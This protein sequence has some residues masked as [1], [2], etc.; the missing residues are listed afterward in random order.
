[1]IPRRAILADM[2][3]VRIGRRAF[4][5]GVGA[6]AG[7]LLARG[8]GVRAGHFRAAADLDVDRTLRELA[9]TFTP[10]GAHAAP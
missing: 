3:D 4:L 9:A 6:G 5:T 1:M 8:L 10:A 2:A 7:L